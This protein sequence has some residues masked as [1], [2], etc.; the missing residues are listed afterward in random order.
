MD[1]PLVYAKTSH[2]L[3]VTSGQ[4]K[5]K[6]RYKNGQ[7]INSLLLRPYISNERSW[8]MALPEGLSQTTF[9]DFW[10]FLTSLVV[11]L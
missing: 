2:A 4:T 3:T 9:S 11:Y 1:N 10:P 8:I 7:A 6:E 5:L